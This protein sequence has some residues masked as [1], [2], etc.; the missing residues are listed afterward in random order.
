MLK[1]NNGLCQLNTFL[2]FFRVSERAVAEPAVVVGESEVWHG[3]YTTVK[4][5]GR[6][7][8]CEY[9]RSEPGHDIR[10]HSPTITFILLSIL[11]SSFLF[12]MQSVYI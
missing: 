7:C 2:S 12:I 5:D 8:Q 11:P 10:S 1:M 9:D 3:V 6:Q 4:K